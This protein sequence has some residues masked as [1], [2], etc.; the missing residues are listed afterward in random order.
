MEKNVME[1]QRQRSVWY[2]R[3]YTV[4]SYRP[5]LC[6]G[7][8]FLVDSDEPGEFI[9]DR[10]RVAGGTSAPRRDDE[11]QYMEV[12]DTPGLRIWYNRALS[13][14]CAVQAGDAPRA[15]PRAV[16]RDDSAM[17]AVPQ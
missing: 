6:R 15:P 9:I 14:C 1:R 11:W 3:P 17:T 8:S 10:E 13:R 2:E 7:L 5:A 12:P 16:A 4:H